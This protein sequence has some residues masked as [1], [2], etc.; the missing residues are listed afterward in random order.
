VN[1]QRLDDTAVSLHGHPF[2]PPVMHVMPDSI[3]NRQSYRFVANVSYSLAAW[4]SQCH[5]TTGV[6]VSRRRFGQITSFCPACESVWEARD[7]P[8]EVG[9]WIDGG[10]AVTR[11][12][13]DRTFERRL[14]WYER[15][16]RAMHDCAEQLQA[17]GDVQPALAAFESAAVEADLFGCTH[18]VEATAELRRHVQRMAP[19]TNRFRDAAD[20]PTAAE[21]RALVAALREGVKTIAETARADLAI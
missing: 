19:Q 17:S 16:I 7:V 18:A 1:P 3:A 12:F 14:D 10:V 5:T 8:K 6:T 4:C 11:S 20:T 21:A 9:S 15:V 13:E 2:A